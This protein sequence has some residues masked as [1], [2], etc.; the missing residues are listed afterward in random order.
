MKSLYIMDMKMTVFE[1]L[2]LRFEWEELAAGFK[3]SQKSGHLE[4]LESFLD[5]GHK[6]NRFRDGYDRAVEIARTIVAES[7]IVTN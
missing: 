7:S 2:A 5:G 3:V 1:L 6:V 4:N